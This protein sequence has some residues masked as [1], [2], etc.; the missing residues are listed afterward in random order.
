MYP[1]D[2]HPLCYKA[3][4]CMYIWRKWWGCFWQQSGTYD[5]W[6]VFTSAWNLLLSCSIAPWIETVLPVAIGPENPLLLTRSWIWG[7]S[8]FWS[9]IWQ[10]TQI[11][12]AAAGGSCHI[13][14]FT[15]VIF[16]NNH[17]S[18]NDADGDSWEIY[19]I[20]LGP[21]FCKGHLWQILSG[22]DYFIEMWLIV[23]KN[24]KTIVLFFLVLLKCFIS[25]FH[26]W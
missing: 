5:G 10:L 22:I 2:T 12:L 18:L 20:V 24:L 13:L 25:V 23:S 9:H 26:L 15:A 3:F 4:Q 16:D 19:F 8:P 21:F 11:Y 7:P 17:Y 6:G 1:P 14:S